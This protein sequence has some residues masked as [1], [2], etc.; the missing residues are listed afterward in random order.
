VK[1]EI[2]FETITEKVTARMGKLQNHEFKK[3]IFMFY[4]AL[5]ED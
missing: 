2:V 1:R 3:A 5:L 4:Q